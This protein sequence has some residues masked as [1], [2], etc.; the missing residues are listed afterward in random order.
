MSPDDTYELEDG[1]ALWLAADC[2][3]KEDFWTLC[4]SHCLSMILYLDEASVLW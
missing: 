4:V 3:V 1:S 2:D